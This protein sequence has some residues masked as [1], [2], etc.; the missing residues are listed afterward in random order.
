MSSSSPLLQ[1]PAQRPGS[2]ADDRAS[3]QRATRRVAWVHL[4]TLFRAWR[5]LL[6]LVALAVLLARTLD[7]VPPLLIQ[8]L[9]DEHLTTGRPAGLLALGWL[10]L[11][12]TVAAQ[13]VN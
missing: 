7:L 12:A 8:R 2:D 5:G 10:Y 4:R 1:S 11:L 6:V 13:A 9:V 3:V